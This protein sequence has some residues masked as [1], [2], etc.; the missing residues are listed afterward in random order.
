VSLNYM[1][2]HCLAVVPKETRPVLLVAGD[3]T[4]S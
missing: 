4:M 1:K 3:A 2:P